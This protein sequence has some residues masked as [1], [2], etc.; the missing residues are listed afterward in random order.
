MT[1]GTGLRAALAIATLCSAAAG[2]AQTSGTPSGPAR[3]SLTPRPRPTPPVGEGETARIAT[4]SAAPACP[5]ADDPTTWVLERG[6]FDG[7]QGDDAARLAPAWTRFAGQ[8]VGNADLCAIRDAAVSILSARGDIAA[9]EIPAQN[10][11]A[12]RV[13][14]TLLF[15]RVRDVRVTGT[16]LRNAAT[17]Q[18]VLAPLTA[19]QRFNEVA[20]ERALLLSADM[21]GHSGRVELVPTASAAGEVDALLDTRY[22]PVEGAVMFHNL[23]GDGA[24]PWNAGVQVRLNSPLGLGDRTTFGV[25]TALD[26]TEQLVAEIV[27]DLPLTAD[28]LGLSLGH[29][30]AWSR[31]GDRVT[32]DVA[33]RTTITQAAMRAAVRRSQALSWFVSGG[34][35][36]A[37]QDVDYVRQPF[38]RDRLTTL[39]ARSELWLSGSGWNA[40]WN[41]ALRKGV[42]D[43]SGRC[44]AAPDP[45]PGIP[46]SQIDADPRAWIV[47]SGFSLSTR[48]APRVALVMAGQ[49]QWS[50]DT[51]VALDRISAG[52]YT[53]GRGLE[54][55]VASG[56]MGLGLSAEV[57]AGPFA[58]GASRTTL[59]PYVFADAMQLWL[60][61]T[62]LPVP[63]QQHIVTAGAGLRARWRAGLSLE[64][65]LPVAVRRDVEAVSTRV[66]P[67]A[68]LVWSF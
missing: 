23:G 64:L 36:R 47:R 51:L 57:R 14:M 53:F 44:D 33:T 6:V 61:P 32:G 68:R 10:I 30:S 26:P 48:I 43:A 4:P 15:V 16:T 56:D 65:T 62:T 37:T 3:D 38:S 8:R 21:P 17:L 54:P 40:G 50:S 42:G 60:H 1:P 29:L 12:G 45:C 19:M 35:E 24:G 34:V 49:G 41:L 20:A 2:H 55:G 11:D 67:T 13:H 52:N 18:R 66:R 39:F 5:Q 22:R 31:S 9:I 46:M 28:G 7:A 59:E 27:Q 58:I 25:T 63:R